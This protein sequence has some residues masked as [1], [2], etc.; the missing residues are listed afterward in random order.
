LN[1]FFV[2]KKEYNFGN[3]KFISFE[4]NNQLGNLQEKIQSIISFAGD[5]FDKFSAIVYGLIFIKYFFFLK[6][7]VNKQFISL[8][9]RPYY[10][11]EIYF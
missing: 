9:E 5:S 6:I 4:L 3:L 1:F 10:E 7:F 8:E 2:Q 11:G